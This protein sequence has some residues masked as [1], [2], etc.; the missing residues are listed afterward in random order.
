MHIFLCRLHTIL[1]SCSKNSPAVTS[2]M[3]YHRLEYQ[4]G[5][6]KFRFTEKEQ[7]RE[8]AR[9]RKRG[10]KEKD[11]FKRDNRRKKEEGQ[12]RDKCKRDKRERRK[13][14]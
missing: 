12:K 9:E 5:F 11:K 7:G 14:N 2:L 8:G 6:D 10:T 13:R 3:V 4:A 1:N